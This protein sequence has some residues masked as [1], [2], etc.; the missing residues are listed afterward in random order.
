MLFLTL[1]LAGM[2]RAE[3]SAEILK[4]RAEIETILK[5]T[6]TPAVSVAVIK[7]NQIEW[8][9]GL[10]M[11]EVVTGR[12]ADADTLFRIGSVSKGFI[13]LAALKLQ[14][15][16]RLDLNAPLASLAPEL[17]CDNPWEATDPVR[18]VHLLEHT[19]GWSDASLRVFALDPPEEVTMAECVELTRSA[20]SSRWKPGTRY[21]YSNVGPA[22]AAYVIEK[23]TGERFEDYIHRTWFGPLDMADVSFFGTREVLQ[24]SAVGYHRHGVTPYPYWKIAMRPSGSINASPRAMANYVLFHVQRGRRNGVALLSEASMTRMETPTTTYAARQGLRAGYG[25]SNYAAARGGWMY[26]G[27]EGDALGSRTGMSYLPGEGAGYAFTINSDNGETFSRVRQALETH[28]TRTRIKPEPVAALPLPA[29]AAKYAGWYEPIN[30]RFNYLYVFERWFGLMHVKLERDGLEMARFSSPTPLVRYVYCGDQFLRGADEPVPTL[31]LLRDSSEGT[32]IQDGGEAGTTYRHLSLPALRIRIGLAVAA[33]LV[34]ATAP[35][36]AGVGLIR[37]VFGRLVF[38][39]TRWLR[40]FP[41]LGVL[42]LLG[43]VAFYFGSL[44]VRVAIS[45]FGRLTPWS[46]G[47]FLFSTLLP[48]FSLGGLV[49]AWRLRREPV[50]KWLWWHSLLVSLALVL[51]SAYLAISGLLA[52]RMWT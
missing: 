51:A 5:E 17:P 24:R 29:E 11:A 7:N 49:E 20:R 22:M 8:V 35:I 12:K 31:A 2:V 41:V 3:E 23:I 52:V 15:E 39:K 45:R 43:F 19:S 33:M 48:L 1:S 34:M 46:G 37:R 6:R 25:L 10:G 27:H 4:L 9:A 36:V 14:E 40:L 30:P 26:H 38:G 44:D 32:L 47:L 50:N 21:A 42:S 18:F 28:V 16:G 13:A